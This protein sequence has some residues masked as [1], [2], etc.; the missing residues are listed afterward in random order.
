MR[1]SAENQQRKFAGCFGLATTMRTRLYGWEI[2]IESS[3]LSPFT[4]WTIGNGK[5]IR[6]GGKICR[7]QIFMK[8]KN[9]YCGNWLTKTSALRRI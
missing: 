7:T 4:G 2:R 8:D 1:F 5:L 6:F 9:F 3:Q